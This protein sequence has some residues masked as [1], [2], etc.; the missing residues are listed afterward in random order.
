LPTNEEIDIFVKQN[1]VIK[2]VLSSNDTQK[3]H[4]KTK[5]YLNKPMLLLL[6]S[7]FSQKKIKH[8]FNNKNK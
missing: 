4:L 7:R 8:K 2:D 5:D 1:F 6:G 3:L